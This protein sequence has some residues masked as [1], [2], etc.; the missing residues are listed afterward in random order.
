MK[1]DQILNKLAGFILVV[2]ILTACAGAFLI[3]TPETSKTGGAL[4]VFALYGVLGSCGL[5]DIA[6]K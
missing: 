1:K 3:A 5:Y 6:N 2:S 4:F